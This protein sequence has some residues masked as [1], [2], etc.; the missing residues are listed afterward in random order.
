MERIE[1]H[2]NTSSDEF[3]RNK[4][5]IEALVK[6]LRAEINRIREGGPEHARKRHVERG[7]LLARERVKKLLDPA[8]PFLELSALAAYGMYDVDS[9]GASIITGVGRIH[10]RETGG[11]ANTATIKRGT[12][13]PMTVEKRLRAQEIA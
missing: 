12:Y 11:V 9:P 3:K 5:A 8:A 1:S 7:K 2:L 13:F 10:G 6:R 4:D